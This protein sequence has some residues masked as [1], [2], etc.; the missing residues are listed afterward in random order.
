[1]REITE[2]LFALRDE[3]Y[4]AFHAALMPGVAWE[5]VIGVRMPALRRYAAA[6]AK[7]P[8]AALFLRELPHT[9][10]EENNLHALLLMREKSF[11]ALMPWLER[12]LPRIDNW[13]TCDLLKPVCFAKNREKL[14]PCVTRWLGD[15]HPYTV[16]FAIEMLMTHY[17][18]EDFS[19]EYPAW[20]AAVESDHYYIRMMQAWYFATA[21]AF[22]YEEILPYLTEDRLS[23]WVRQKP[24]KRQ[25]RA[26]ASPRSTR[27]SSRLC[28]AEQPLISPRNRPFRGFFYSLFIPCVCLFC[29][30]M[31][32][33]PHKTIFGSDLC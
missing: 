2:A 6:L 33:Y 7:T 17:L 10:Y 19:P 14:L 26:S 29:R 3:K 28:A 25:W 16:R 27:L 31:V 20:V 8:Q 23:P 4:R 15:A 22:R 18:R 13:A 11:E 5:R 24:S 1:M 9:Y 32:K 12:F 30:S 21:L